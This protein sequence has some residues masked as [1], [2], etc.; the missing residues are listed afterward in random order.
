MNVEA[1]NCLAGAKLEFALQHRLLKN[2]DIPVIIFKQLGNLVQT[3]LKLLLCG[4]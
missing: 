1:C 4:T 3:G 2:Q